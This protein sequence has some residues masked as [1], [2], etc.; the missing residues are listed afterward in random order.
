MKT[1]Y[2]FNN[3]SELNKHLKYWSNACG[4]LH[5]HGEYDL[6]D[7]SELPD[8][9]Q[10]AYKE[11]WKEGYGCL[12]YLVEY[13]GKYYVALISEFDDD[14]AKNSDLSMDELYEIVKKNAFKLYNEDL[15][16]NTI[17]VIGKETGLDECHEFIF[18]VPAMESENIYDEIEDEIYINIWKDR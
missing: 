9:L 11:L 2:E 4:E 5:H 8:E 7:I 14:F 18:L 13:D 17:L 1:Y 12:E 3:E 15:F 10:R 6:E 16:K